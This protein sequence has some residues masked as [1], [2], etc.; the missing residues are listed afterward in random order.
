MAKFTEMTG[1]QAFRKNI[2]ISDFKKQVRSG[3]THHTIQ[4]LQIH[5][6]HIAHAIKPCIQVLYKINHCLGRPPSGHGTAM[7]HLLTILIL[8]YSSEQS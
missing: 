6:D 5:T 8:G 3:R 7:M 2:F 4:V 1:L